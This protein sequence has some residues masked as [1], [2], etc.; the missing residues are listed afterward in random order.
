[1]KP[2]DFV[3]LNAQYELIKATLIATNNNMSKTAKLLRIDPK[4]LYNKIK[5]YSRAIEASASS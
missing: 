1:M 4:T 3:A 5:K 2:F